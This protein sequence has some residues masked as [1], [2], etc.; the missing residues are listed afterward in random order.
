MV[1]DQ[2]QQ[3]GRTELRLHI[4]RDAVVRRAR[5]EY[6]PDN[7][8]NMVFFPL[9]SNRSPFQYS[10]SFQR[11]ESPPSSASGASTR[12]RPVTLVSCRTFKACSNLTHQL[13]PMRTSC[14]Q[15]VSH[16]NGSQYLRGVYGIPPLT[17]DRTVSIW[18][19]CRIESDTRIPHPMR[20]QQANWE[21]TTRVHFLGIMTSIS[22][23]RYINN[24]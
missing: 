9:G 10:I 21:R 24:S 11:H 1:I 2:K 13:I 14:Q 15:V 6:E 20:A 5:L 3:L 16:I 8:E 17:E 23:P 19:A 7:E 12:C 4:D 22:A 18:I